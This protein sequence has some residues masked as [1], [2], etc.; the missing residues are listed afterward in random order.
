MMS[1]FEE[2][3]RRNREMIGA[4]RRAGELQR[5][6]REWFL[7]ASRHEYSYHFT[8]LGV[9]IIQFPQDVVAMQEIIWRVRPEVIIETGVARGGSLVFYASMLELLGRGEVVGVDVDLRPHNR[10]I[11]EA[12]PLARR[13][14]LIDGSSIAESV[15]AEVRERI[16][17]KRPVVVVLDSNHTHEHV[18]AELKLYSPMVTV[19]SYCVVMDT[20]I[21]VMPDEFVK[22]RPW[23]VGDNPMTAVREF[24]RTDDRFEVDASM[25][26]KLLIT[27][28]PDGYLKRLR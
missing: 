12:H 13:I 5:L 21:E 3:E 28:A 9:P 6:S 18:A 8:W 1:D 16:G 20:V 27:V 25:A 24:L 22:D 14:H 2:F 19:G 23:K 17:S 7:E 11:V 10:E 4:M 15:V 26:G